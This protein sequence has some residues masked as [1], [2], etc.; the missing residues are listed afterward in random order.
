M[1][2]LRLALLVAAILSWNACSNDKSDS[3]QGLTASILT[4]ASSGNAGFDES[5]LATNS[6]NEFGNPMAGRSTEHAP[7]WPG[8]DF[9]FF[10]QTVLQTGGTQT[11]T[12][13]TRTDSCQFGGTRTLSGTQTINVTQNPDGSST[14]DVTAGTRS[15]SF[16]HCEANGRVTI[17]SGTITLTQTGSATLVIDTVTTTD[18]TRTRHTLSGLTATVSG[19]IERTIEGRRRGPQTGT[20]QISLNVTTTNRVVH[21]QDDGSGNLSNPTL[22]SR[23]GSIQGTVNAGSITRTINRTF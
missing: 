20:V 21:W 17:N 8:L 2:K 7:L 16:D 19:S 18:G 3:N 9:G 6:E 11:I 13:P 15:V 12:L 5:Q 22:I 10:D 23:S 1:N 4:A 14:V